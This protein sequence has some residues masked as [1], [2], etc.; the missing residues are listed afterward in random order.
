MFGRPKSPW[1]KLFPEI[2]DLREFDRLCES[3]AGRLLAHG[4]PICAV[5]RRA[6][7]T[8]EHKSLM[9]VYIPSFDGNTRYNIHPL[10]CG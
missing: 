7:E 8:S 5:R 6:G 4:L 1:L 3:N 10:T 9:Y 2:S